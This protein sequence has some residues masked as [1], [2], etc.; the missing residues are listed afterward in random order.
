MQ[1]VLSKKP[2]NGMLKSMIN[3]KKE[4]KEEQSNQKI[5]K[6]NSKMADLNTSIS[7]ITLNINGLYTSN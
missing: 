2:M 6:T 5:D 3:S 1:R 4:E 7:I